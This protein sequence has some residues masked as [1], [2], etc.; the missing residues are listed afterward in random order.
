[1]KEKIT[2]FIFA[3]ILVLASCSERKETDASLDRAEQMMSQHPDS[4]LMILNNIRPTELRNERQRALYALLLTQARDKNYLDSLQSDSLMKTAVDF[5][6]KAGNDKRTLGKAY[7]YYAK[8]EK[9]NSN[10]ERALQYYLKAKD[11]LEDVKDH[12]MLSFV[13][14]YI[15]YVYTDRYMYDLAISNYKKAI[16][17]ETLTKDTLKLMYDYRNLAWNYMDKHNYDSV[18]WYASK[19]NALLNNDSLSP[20]YPSIMHLLGMCDERDKNYDRAISRM[21]KAISLERYSG[22]RLQY[23]LALS[24]VY[25]KIGNFDEAEGCL[26]GLF[27]AKSLFSRAGAYYFTAKVKKD[28]GDWH[29]AL[30]YREISD[31]LYDVYNDNS[32]RDRISELQS[33]HDREKIEMEN[34]IIRQEKRLQL[35]GWGLL[36]IVIVTSAVVLYRRL[37]K[38]YILTYKERMKKQLHRELMTY[39]KNEE[40]IK[41]YVCEIEMLKQKDNDAKNEIGNLKQRLLIL[42]NENREIRNNPNANA[43]YLI[44]QLKG[45]LLIVEN[46]TK[47]ERTCILDYVDS[48]YNN[49]VTNLRT[50]YSLND[51]N[52]LFAVFLKL[53]FSNAELIIVYD[54]EENSVY[55]KKQRLKE[56]LNLGKE[57]SLEAFL[58]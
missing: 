54:C 33:A 58:R 34:V 57:D 1:M 36:T 40:Q 18:N 49:F 15:G 39:R 47:Q 45:G 4:S 13:H 22:L 41:R 24:D 19:A 53:G 14:Q 2:I 26:Q 52:I 42:K 44:Q 43:L 56:R 31:S 9:A 17:Y 38:R 20:V 11:V 55:R 35:Y 51:N 48:F 21:K 27:N 50:Q 23:N 25:R 8:L 46:V 28:R 10:P 3:W 12:E 16:E 37:R 29:A 30:K 32:L 6:E 7:F 5:Y